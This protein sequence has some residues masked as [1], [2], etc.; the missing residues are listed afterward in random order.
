MQRDLGKLGEAKASILHAIIIAHA[1]KSPRCVRYALIGLGELRIAEALL[2]CPFQSLHN[3]S[4]H[5]QNSLDSQ[6]HGMHEAAPCKRLLLRARSTLQRAL[7]LAEL[8]IEAF[9]DGKHLLATAY[10]LLDDSKLARQ[11]AL[12]TLKAAQENETGRIVGRANRLLGRILT[13]QGHYEQADL[14]FEQALTIFREGSLQLDY[15]RTLYSYGTILFQRGNTVNAAIH[16]TPEEREV[17]LQQGID[18]LHEARRIFTN[19]HASVDLSLVLPLLV[20][21][22]V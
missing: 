15:A 7:S 17:R 21:F 10:Y 20:R 12:Q 3:I 8:D 22:E 5:T 14:Y 2:A 16:W 9:T 1:I 4:T 19:C 11:A 13:S 18:Y 6:T